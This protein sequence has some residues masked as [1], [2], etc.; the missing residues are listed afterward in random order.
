MTDSWACLSIERP[1]QLLGPT[2]FLFIG[3]QG[4]IS[5]SRKGYTPGITANNTKT[6]IN[7]RQ[8]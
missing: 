2:S 6:L 8:A 4:I 7:I 3:Y 5:Y 1:G